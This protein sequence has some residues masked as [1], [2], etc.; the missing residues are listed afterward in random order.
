MVVLAVYTNMSEP[1]EV[2]IHSIVGLFKCVVLFTELR[3]QKSV[4]NKLVTDHA[5]IINTKK[6]NQKLKFVNYLMVQS[7]R[8]ITIRNLFA[9]LQVRNE[10]TRCPYLSYKPIIF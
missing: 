2:T 4:A 9:S 3:E 1:L 8:P 7:N 5:S 10:R 6:K